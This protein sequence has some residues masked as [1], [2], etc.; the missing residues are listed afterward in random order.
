MAVLGG[1]LPCSGEARDPRGLVVLSRD[2]SWGGLRGDHLLTLDFDG[3]A[4]LRWE[5]K[6]YTVIRRIL[7]DDGDFDGRKMWCTSR[8]SSTTYQ[9]GAPPGWGL[10]SLEACSPMFYCVL[11]I[12]ESIVSGDR[13]N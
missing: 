12:A 2:A 4:I 7:G 13:I 8:P 3:I 6:V 10:D 5:M 9:L 1:D 11:F